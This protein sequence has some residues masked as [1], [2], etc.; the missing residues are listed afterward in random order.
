ML[1]KLILKRY[2][3][4]WKFLTVVFAG[5]LLSSTTMSGSLM[6][7]DSLRDIALDFELSKISSEKLDVNIASSE[8]P[9]MGDKYLNLKKDIED[10]LSIPLKKYSTQNFYGTKTSTFLPTEWG[11]TGEEMEKGATSR[12]TSLCN[13]SEQIQNN[14]AID[15]CKRYY[16]SFLENV[17]ENNL[18]NFDEVSSNTNRDLVEVFID[19]DIANLFKIMP[20]E[21][22]EIEAYWDEADPIV[23]VYIS[24]FFSLGNNNIFNSFYSQNFVQEDSSFI[25]ANLIIKEI[26]SLKELGDKFISMD[27]DLFWMSDIDEEKINSTE[28][29]KINSIVVDNPPL[30]SSKYDNFSFKTG[31]TDSLEKFDSNQLF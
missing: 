23:N 25:F 16:F 28:V 21:I 20:G 8:K 29:T 5:M 17:T 3:H 6:Y 12:L 22:L 4:R 31:I 15:I 10:N 11:K 26:D 7:F 18:I 13:S 30:L 14:N 27:S 19:K 9:L 2:L 24:G 1:F